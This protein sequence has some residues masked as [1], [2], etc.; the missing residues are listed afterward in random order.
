MADI[1]DIVRSVVSYSSEG[2][3]EQ[4]NVFYH[5]IRDMGIG[6][7]ALL[8]E[9]A[10]WV[11]MEWAPLWQP[12]ASGD[13]EIVSVSCDLMNPDGTVKVNIG[14]DPILVSGSGPSA[15]T[16]AAV[17]GYLLA[18]TALPKTRGSKYVPGIDEVAITEGVF[19]SAAVADLI[20]LAALY[21]SPISTAIGANLFAGVLSR[22]LL[23]FVEFITEVTTTDVPAYQRRRKPNVGS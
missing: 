15:V 14:I 20:L 21:I 23:N 6:N 19:N 12:I 18:Q 8:N 11:A 2:A 5:E 9:I 3:S 16:A 17:S 1:G 13:S 22:T 4:Q 7:P 10:D